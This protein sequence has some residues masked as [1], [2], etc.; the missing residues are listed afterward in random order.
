L[1]PWKQ[2]VKEIAPSVIH[3]VR[4]GRWARNQITFPIVAS[5]IEMR[6][7][8]R[9]MSGPFEGLRAPG[10][11]TGGAGYYTELLGIYEKCL[12]PVIESVIA[13]APAIIVDAGANWGY[14]ALGLAMRCPASRVIAYEI[15]S[16]RADL[17]R[18]FR[19]LNNLDEHVEVRGSCT[20]ETL[21]ADLADPSDSFLLMDVEGAEDF[22]LDPLRAPGLRRAE[23]LIELHD[24]FVPGVTRRIE[25]RFH[26]THEQTLLNF[27][28]SPVGSALVGWVADYAPFRRTLARML[29]EGRGTDMSWIHLSPRS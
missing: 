24:Q 26:E 13:R 15:D 6:A 25:E 8:G 11:G 5:S 29:D 28:P 17:L 9:I 4:A 1:E 10:S 7:A 3:G 22:L 14:Y 27:E 23:M 21:A 16:I 18:K 12:V 20:V 2:T 19:G